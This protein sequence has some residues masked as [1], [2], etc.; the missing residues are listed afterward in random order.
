VGE[1]SLYRQT[2]ARTPIRLQLFALA[3]PCSAEACATARKMRSYLVKKVIC[4]VVC[5]CECSL[6][7]VKD[8]RFREACF[9]I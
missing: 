2:G 1:G 6:Q 9:P 4:H 5:P 7:F 8:H 3:L